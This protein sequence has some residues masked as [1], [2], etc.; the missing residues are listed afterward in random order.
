MAQLVQPGNA[1]PLGKNPAANS[2]RSR[3]DEIVSK[4][5]TLSFPEGEVLSLENFGTRGAYNTVAAMSQECG[6]ELQESYRA[7]FSESAKYTD[8]VADR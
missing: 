8:K 2:T 1:M 7:Q 3:E 5:R 4:T 6:K